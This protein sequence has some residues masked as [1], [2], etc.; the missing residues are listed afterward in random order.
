MATRPKT[1]Q[2]APLDAVKRA[3]SVP[4]T[5]KAAASRKPAAVKA[6]SPTD[7]KAGHKK[8]KT[9]RDSFNMPASDYALIG[10]LKMRALKSAQHVKKSELLRAGLKMLAAQKD[11]EFLAALAAVDS[12][13]TGRPPKKGN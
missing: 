6:I 12:I 1:V 8:Q 3:A 7:R 10:D 9:I 13:K 5:Q 4:K 2:T 11:A